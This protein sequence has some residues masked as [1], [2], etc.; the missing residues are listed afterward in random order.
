VS[1]T[2]DLD[3]AIQTSL[4][5]LLA[6][7]D[8]RPVGE[9]RFRLPA[10]SVSMFDR[11]FGGQLLAQAVVGAAATVEGK[12]IH[13]LHATFVKAG[14]PGEPLE[15][16]VTRI[17]DGR[18]FATRQVALLEDGAPLLVGI[19]SFTSQTDEPDVAVALPDVAPPEELPQESVAV[20]GDRGLSRGAIHDPAGRLVASVAQEVVIRKVAT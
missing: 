10:E 14:C 2:G 9:D 19:A 15:V 5:N 7:L 3:V 12:E 6:A 18:S 11:A 8:L 17:R 1:V 13:S 20:I 4:D 16:G